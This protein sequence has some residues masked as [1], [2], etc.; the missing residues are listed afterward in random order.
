MMPGG[1]IRFRRIC[2]SA[3]HHDRAGGVLAALRAAAG[4]RR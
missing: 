4:Q 1:A 2:G 3:D